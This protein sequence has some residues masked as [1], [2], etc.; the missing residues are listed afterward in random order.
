V[1][2]YE[3]CQSWHWDSDPGLKVIYFTKNGQRWCLV[4]VQFQHNLLS[5]AKCI[6]KYRPYRLKEKQSYRRKPEHKK[7][8]LSV[9]EMNRREWKENKRNSKVDWK[10]HGGIGREGKT[11]SARAERRKVKE[12]LANGK[13]HLIHRKLAIEITDPW[14]WD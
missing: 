8:H 4:L 11:R 9:E 12:F 7:K 1:N 14:A 5:N 10:R 6:W 2:I 13:D 3:K